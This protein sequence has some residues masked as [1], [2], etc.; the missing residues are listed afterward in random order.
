MKQSTMSSD[1]ERSVSV[2]VTAMATDKDDVGADVR[3]AVSAVDSV[4][5]Q[6]WATPAAAAAATTITTTTTTPLDNN[7]NNDEHHDC[8]EKASADEY[9]GVYHGSTQRPTTPALYSRLPG[10]E[11]DTSYDYN[12]S[13]HYSSRYTSFQAP[14]SSYLGAVTPYAAPYSPSALNPYTFNLAGPC[15]AGAAY[16]APYMPHHLTSPSAALLTSERSAPSYRFTASST[17]LMQ[18]RT[19]SK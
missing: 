14:S 5:S 11:F 12:Y 9:R 10:T 1:A 18:S 6:R 19:F 16:N 2:T 17:S 7:N 4:V 13:P 15:A 8:I 3:L